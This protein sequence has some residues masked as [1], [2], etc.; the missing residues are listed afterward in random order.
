MQQ[1]PPPMGLL[2]H[3]EAFRSTLVGCALALLITCGGVACFLP[4]MA[5]L[6]MWPL[7]QAMIDEPHL[8]Q[9]LVT[10]SPMGVFSVLLQVCLLGGFALALPFIFFLLGRFIAPALTL[11][12]K[13]ALIPAALSALALFLMG[14]L[15]SY[16]WLLPTSLKVAIELNRMFGFE[17]IWS[18][19]HYYGLVVWMTLGIG[20]C[21][22]FPLVLIVLIALGVVH[23]ATLAVYRRHI[24]VGILILS[25]FITPGG[26]PL[27]LILLAIPLYGLFEL[28][29]IIGRRFETEI[30]LSQN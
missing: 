5:S 13:Q 12:E 1:T 29:L 6:L 17:L 8:L 30:S 22:E 4:E 7:H 16:L 10:T 15:F 28:S 19:P 25:A 26:D 24:I 2:Q 11:R 18:A 9:G 23:T 20:L 14:A 21:F 27:S 3:L